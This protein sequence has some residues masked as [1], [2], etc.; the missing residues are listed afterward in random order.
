M[1]I[2][3]LSRAA[4]TALIGCAAAACSVWVETPGDTPVASED[5]GGEAPGPLDLEGY[6][7]VDLS[8]A[9]SGETVYWPTDTAGFTLDEL[10]FGVTEA[11]YFYSAYSLATAEHGGTHIDAPIHFLEGGPDVALIPLRRL[12]GPAVVID[13]TAQA[14]EDADYRLT[15]ADVEAHEAEH[16]PIEPGSLVLLRTG[17]STRWPD[18]LSYL[19]DD[20]PGDASQ[21]HFPSYGEA[22]ARLLV[23]ERGAAALGAD[24]ASIDYGASTDFVVHRIVAAANAPGLENLTNLDLLPARGATVIA[25]PM[26]IA[27]GSGGPL[28]AI[29]LVPSSN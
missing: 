15:V 20:T 1:A 29:A 9:F 17:W 3:E 23:E 28:R 21:L 13:M 22:A 8:H 16:G 4:A 7:L 10:A 11:G 26:K 25:L 14:A 12:I 18:P 19:G 27:G 5:A 2:S 6:S 24:V